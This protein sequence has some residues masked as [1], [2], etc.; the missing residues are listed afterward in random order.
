MRKSTVLLLTPV[1]VLVLLTA[2]AI[3]EIPGLIS[4]QGAL[5]GAGNAALDTT[6]AMTFRIFDDSTAGTALW[7]ETQP[8]VAVAGG[9]FNVLLGTVNPLSY[10]VF[11]A[12]DRWLGIQV[13]GDPEL[14]PRQRVA[15]TGY[16]FRAAGA[17]TAEYARSSSA[18][19]D[20]DWTVAG[21]DMYAA[22]PGKVGIGT[23]A[24][25]V[26]LD[27]R[28]RLNVG[29]EGTGHDVHLYGDASGGRLSWDDGH[30]SLRAGRD[31][32]GT[33]WLSLGNYSVATGYNTE[34][35]GDY[36]LAH[37]DRSTAGGQKS[38]AMGFFASAGG[39][40]SVAV[41]EYISA[42]TVNTI[43]LG[44]GQDLSN[45]LIN[46]TPNSLM[47]GFGSTQPTLFVGGADARVGVGTGDPAE[48]LDVAGTVKTTGFR[49]TT[50]AADGHVMISDAT[51]LGSWRP[52]GAV[53]DS[54]WTLAGDDMYTAA[55]GNVG[56]GTSSPDSRLDVAGDINI[57]SAYKI[58]G[59]TVLVNTGSYNIFLG[60]GA[61]AN[62]SGNWNTFLG[63]ESGYAN[64]SGEHNTFLGRRTGYSNNT[65]LRNT[66]V[67]D[68]CGRQNTAGSYNTSLG[69]AAGY[70][71]IS[72]TGNVFIGYY[73]GYGETGSDKL[74]IANGTDTSNVLLYGDFSTGHLGVG[75]LNPTEHLHVDGSARVSDT[76]FVNGRVGI[77]TTAPQAR[78]HA[79][80]TYTGD[81]GIYG[82]GPVGIHG[83][84]Y[85]GF[86]GSWSTAVK[87]ETP[88]GA[89]FGSLGRYFGAPNYYSAGVYGYGG[90]ASDYAGKFDG[91]VAMYQFQMTTSPSNG[92][93][94]TSDASGNGSWQPP[95]GI[96]LPYSDTDSSDGTLFLIANVDSGAAI[97]GENNEGSEHTGCAIA[98]H[99]DGILCYTQE[100]LG[101]AIYAMAMGMGYAHYAWSE[102]RGRITSLCGSASI[103]A[104]NT[105]DSLFCRI[106]DWEYAVHAWGTDILETV[107]KIGGGLWVLGDL[108]KGASITTIDHPLDPE[109]MLLSHATMESPEPLAV[110]RGKARL[111][112]TG[113]GVVSL[114]D[115][116]AAFTR[117]EEATV[118]LTPV[119]KP[120]LSG[121]DWR[122]GN[123]EFKIY[124]QPDREVSW[125][126]YAQRDD[127]YMR[128]SRYRVE[129]R[130]SPDS[131]CDRGKL[132]HPVAYGYPDNMSSDYQERREA[133]EEADPEKM[134]RTVELSNLTR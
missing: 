81:E 27:L 26:E 119:G 99:L 44:R 66:F 1:L 125:V 88:D 11:T 112:G 71:N 55:S 54:D 2:A 24:P 127:P 111:D 132:L 39:D 126:V 96:E 60:A 18:A 23:S 87:G 53:A 29:Q 50:G 69:Y 5:T 80:T 82:E 123:R 62:N 92:Y 79:T 64:T 100:E 134:R 40:R 128:M 133:I 8:G 94:L 22:V 73:A 76:L 106:A 47:V 107:A 35:G 32:D 75:T 89:T 43:A 4:F 105:A 70:S 108:T 67:G 68:N 104:A 58:G 57:N 63:A 78:L 37:G 97:R 101:A 114:P 9:I 15:A 3:A 28:G 65:G 84:G 48:K 30:M 131:I 33:H 38:I 34:A 20:G 129:K 61:G 59:S 6:V 95:A 98:T 56:I 118:I 77:G 116:F 7:T 51:G 122:P 45:P 83:K 52:A 49:M 109:N 103:Y 120:F 41:G 31:S 115:Y 117:E 110:Y 21:S 130:K 42:D 72:G 36:S 121:Y 19:S 16:A 12:P 93:V 124:G 113:E 85:T 13:G 74:Y 46:R 91:K 25:L 86:P 14:A 90:T 10:Q 102:I 17:D